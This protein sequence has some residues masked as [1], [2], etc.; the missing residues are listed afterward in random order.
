[1]E[2]YDLEEDEVVLYKGKVSLQNQK[3]IT[4]LILTNI[5]FVL[6]TKQKKLFSNPKTT[7][8]IML[9]P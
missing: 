6:I 4:E 8:S 7:Q 3:G 1:M 5:N 2:H 9:L